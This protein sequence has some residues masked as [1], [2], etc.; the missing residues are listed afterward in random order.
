MSEASRHC[1]HRLLELAQRLHLDAGHPTLA[2]IERVAG[3]LIDEK[4]RAGVEDA[5]KRLPTSTVSEYLSGKSRLPDWQFFHTFVA[6]CHRI[7]VQ[8]DLDV[9]PPSEL[10]AEFGA[11]WKAAKAETGSAPG[12]VASPRWTPGDILE[13]TVQE[14][15]MEPLPAVGFR[16]PR[17]WGRSGAAILRRAAMGDA[18]AAYQAAILLACEAAIKPEDACDRKDL[19]SMAAFYRGKATGKVEQAATLR[20]AGPPLHNAA[21][22]LALGH[23]RSGKPCVIFFRA[24]L[25]VEAALRPVHATFIVSADL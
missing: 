17:A 23:K 7:A 2:T 10:M 24:F 11:L 8:N 1:Q 3:D 6:V 15:R 13:P 14:V 9:P 4:Q 16:M 5:W 22:S 19:L 18:N 20:L 25:Q 21:R 12:Y